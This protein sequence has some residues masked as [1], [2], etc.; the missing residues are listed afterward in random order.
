VYIFGKSIWL[1]FLLVG[2]CARLA[3]NVPFELSCGVATRESPAHGYLLITSFHVSCERDQCWIHIRDYS[4]ST[5]ERQ[6]SCRA[7]WFSSYAFNYSDFFFTRVAVSFTTAVIEWTDTRRMSG[8]ERPDPHNL[9]L[10]YRPARDQHS[11]QISFDALGTT[12]SSV[13]YTL[14]TR[15]Y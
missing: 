12:Y 7:L 10:C 2:I 1:F 14:Y 5:E 6:T 4:T 15:L 8:N 13:R 11:K 9:T 3:W